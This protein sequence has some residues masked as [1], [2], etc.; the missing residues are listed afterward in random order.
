MKGP[1]LYDCINYMKFDELLPLFRKFV[2]SSTRSGC[3]A[4]NVHS[5]FYL[6]TESKTKATKYSIRR[7]VSARP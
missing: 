7:N 1:N 4:T 5:Q 6:E 2:R 3:P